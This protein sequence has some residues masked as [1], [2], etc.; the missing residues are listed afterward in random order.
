MTGWLAIDLMSPSIWQMLPYYLRKDGG[1]SIFIPNVPTKVLFPH[2]QYAESG[3]KLRN[4]SSRVKT[5]TTTSKFRVPLNRAR[6]IIFLIEYFI[7]PVAQMSSRK[8][9][10]NYDV[11]RPLILFVF[12]QELEFWYKS[13]SAYCAYERVKKVTTDWKKVIFVFICETKFFPNFIILRIRI[14]TQRKL[15]KCCCTKQETQRVEIEV[16][17]P[18]RTG[19]RSGNLGGEYICGG[20]G[21]ICPLL[22]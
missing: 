12:S 18:T 21:I 5:T 6:N 10:S 4:L 11:G 16:V 20:G 8:R 19:G 15:S 14:L 2:T 9:I 3:F 1:H 13:T 22:K 7:S 17:S